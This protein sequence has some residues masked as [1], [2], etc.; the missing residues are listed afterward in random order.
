ML[1]SVLFKAGS[2]VVISDVGLKPS[3][4]VVI[5]VAADLKPPFALAVA[6]AAVEDLCACSCVS[7]YSHCTCF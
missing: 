3:F 5:A 1:S 7:G 6:A 4:T 2:A